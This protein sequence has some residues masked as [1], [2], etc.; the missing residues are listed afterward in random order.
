VKNHSIRIYI[1][2]LETSIKDLDELAYGSS[3][4]ERISHLAKVILKHGQRLKILQD[5]CN[6]TYDIYSKL[7]EMGKHRETLVNI[8][9]K[10]VSVLII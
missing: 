3:E 6:D 4:A 7:V 2:I 5:A 10:S 8:E 9:R 1:M